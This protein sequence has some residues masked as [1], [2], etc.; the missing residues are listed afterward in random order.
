MEIHTLKSKTGEV[1]GTITGMSDAEFRE[2][3]R[4]NVLAKKLTL[5]ARPMLVNVSLEEGHKQDWELVDCPICKGKCW[6]RPKVE[7]HPMPDGV[8][9]VCTMCMLKQGAAI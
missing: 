3:V 2:M 9:P 7:W 4:V 8:L 6:K 1:I 5:L